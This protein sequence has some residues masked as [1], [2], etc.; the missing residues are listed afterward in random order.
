MTQPNYV[1]AELE[2]VIRDFTLYQLREVL[3]TVSTDPS[4]GSLQNKNKEQLVSLL[5]RIGD[6]RKKALVAHRLETLTAYK[7]LFV[8]AV[9]RVTT[10]AEASTECRR[11]FPKL[12]DGFSP[13]PSDASSLHF[14]LCLLDDERRRIF[15]KFAHLVESWETFKTS[16]SERVQRR[17]KKRHPVVATFYADMGILV[18]S[19]PGFTQTGT[20]F[21]ERARYTDI[22]DEAAS[23]AIQP[24]AIELEGLQ[25]KNAIESLLADPTEQVFDVR[26]SIKPQGG[27]RIV[28]DSWESEAGLA[29][30]LAAFFKEGNVALDAD[31]VR[32]L[33]QSGTDDDIWLLWRK[34]D[35]L[36]RF[37]FHDTTSEVLVLW[38]ESGP[39]LSKTE[40]VLIALTSHRAAPPPSAVL[41]AAQDIENST[42]GTIITPATLSQRHSLSI[43]EALRVLTSAV[44][45]GRV[46]LRFRVKTESLLENF[47]NHWRPTLVD[48]P[49]SVTDE[50]GNVID[51]VDRRNI[52]V[53]FERVG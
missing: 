8:Y 16:G 21:K 43:D 10:Y 37:A 51:L 41:A 44:H 50:A 19:F 39:D 31:R 26:R 35:L 45:R 52:E 36:T 17:V 2:G 46:E 25:V 6:G 3:A 5:G 32:N 48:F 33:L 28:V 30:Y 24:L 18:V 38:R 27:G 12:V 9:K 1:D 22:A 49:P 23:L 47:Q 53:A 13:M 40:A 29:K 42:V 14:Q 34:L 20:N 11:R 4:L 15:L 7:H